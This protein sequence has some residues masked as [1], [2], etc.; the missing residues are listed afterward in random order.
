MSSPIQLPLGIQLRDDATFANYYSG[1]NQPVVMALSLD[2]AEHGQAEPYVFIYG[3]PGVG[4]SH[5]LQA[6]CHEADLH[7]LKSVYLPLAELLPYGPGVLDSLETLDVICI[8]EL[9]AVAGNRQWEVALFHLFNRVKD[10]KRRLLIAAS[11]PPKD[12][13]IHLPDLLSRLSWG[14]VFQVLPLTDE[15]KVTALQ[16]RAHMRGLDVSD[17]VARYILYRAPRS[18]QALFS[19]LDQ[20]DKASLR[21][22]RKLTIPFVKQVMDW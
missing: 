1:R 10:A 13:G 8:D 18:T 5:L 15:E 21:A 22:K 9:Q 2:A 17:E 11:S 12:T 19:A 3:S 14:V 4:C 20:L 16:L 7:Q 6:A